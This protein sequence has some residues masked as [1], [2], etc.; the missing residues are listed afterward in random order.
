M[1]L[2]RCQ[3]AAAEHRKEM[4]CHATDLSSLCEIFKLRNYG[5]H[6]HHPETAA[7]SEQWSSDCTPGV[8]AIPRQAVTAPAALVASPA[9]EQR[10]TYKLAVLTHKV[11]STSTP[12]FLHDRIT[13]RVCTRTLCSSAIPLLVQPFTTGQTSRRAVRCLAPSVWNSLPQRVL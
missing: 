11:W 13:E 7:S 8:E 2:T 3:V 9:A 6:Y 4:S 12:V 5:V 10:I 1:A